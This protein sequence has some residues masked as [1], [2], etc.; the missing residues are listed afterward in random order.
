MSDADDSDDIE[1]I[2]ERK[3]EEL[4]TQIEG[5]GHATDMTVPD[6]PISVDDADHFSRVLEEHSLVL[7]DFYADWCGPCQMLAPILEGLAGDIPAAIAKVDTE[8][9][10]TLAQ[11]YG[12]RGL[13]TLVLVEDGEPAEQLVGMQEESRLRQVIERHASA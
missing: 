5:D 6:E 12:V 2:R 11:Q 9:L 7:V 4:R 10:P 13:P 3:L 1:K 8:A